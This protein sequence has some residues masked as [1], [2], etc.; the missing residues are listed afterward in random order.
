MLEGKIEGR[1]VNI[2]L[3]PG[4][5]GYCVLQKEETAEEGYRIIAAGRLSW[6]SLMNKDGSDSSSAKAK[7]MNNKRKN[8]VAL[9]LKLLFNIAIHYKCSE[10]IMENL[11]FSDTAVSDKSRESNRKCNN[12]WYRKL[13]YNIINRRC[14]ENGIRLVKTNACYTSFMG[15][16]TYDSCDSTNASAVIGRR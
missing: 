1:S 16:I 11:D 4:D 8:A 9:A 6:E 14:V 10:F 15:N 2:D 5:I 3:N 13:S 7:R 12:I